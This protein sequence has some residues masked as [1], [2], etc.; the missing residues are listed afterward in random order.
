MDVAHTETLTEVHR[1][2]YLIV[3][4]VFIAQAWQVRRRCNVYRAPVRAWQV[5]TAYVNG[6]CGRGAQNLLP[7]TAQGLR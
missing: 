5:R 4:L 2:L 1:G 7:C 3:I 6:C